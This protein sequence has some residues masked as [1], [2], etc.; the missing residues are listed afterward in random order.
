MHATVAEGMMLWTIRALPYKVSPCSDQYPLCPSKEH[1]VPPRDSL[2]RL[3]GP[4]S[5]CECSN[6]GTMGLARDLCL[7]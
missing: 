1:T 3:I 2:F 4:G 7:R 6:G 5:S